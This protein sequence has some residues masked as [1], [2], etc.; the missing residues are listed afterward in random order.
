MR[1]SDDSNI[2]DTIKRNNTACRTVFG[3]WYIDPMSDCDG[4]NMPRFTCRVTNVNTDVSVLYECPFSKKKGCVE[5]TMMRVIECYNELVE[6]KKLKIKFNL[7]RHSVLQ[8]HYENML[9]DALFDYI[10]DKYSDV[11]Y[12]DYDFKFKKNFPKQYTYISDVDCP[13]MLD[14]LELIELED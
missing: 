7:L 5:K 9:M 12:F 1:L 6:H 8:R 11:Y 14:N 3:K 2:K 13:D 4:S 10:Q